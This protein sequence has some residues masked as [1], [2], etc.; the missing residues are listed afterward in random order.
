MKNQ[1]KVIFT[2]ILS[3]SMSLTAG[4]QAKVYT[5]KVLMED[6][7]IKTAKMLINPNS[8]LDLALKTEITSRWRVSPYEFCTREEYAAISQDNSFYCMRIASDQGVEFL[9]LE[10]CGKEKDP[11]TFKRSFEVVRIPLSAE[12]SPNGNEIF[13]LGAYVDFIQSFAEEAMVSDR[14]GYTG[15]A[16]YR[17]RSLKGKTIYMNENDIPDILEQ[18]KE[19]ALLAVCVAPVQAGPKTRCYKMLIS[20]DTHELFYYSSDKYKGDKNKFFSEKEIKEF[21]LRNAVIIR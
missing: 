6:F 18:G 4:G 11:D 20:A 14:V 3:V 16:N 1:L 10:K 19:D 13:L 12:D 7:H 2:V 8:T 17:F 9:V 21:E 5:R 15:L